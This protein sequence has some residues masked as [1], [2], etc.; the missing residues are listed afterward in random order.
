MVSPP[1]FLPNELS[2]Y[3]SIPNKKEMVQKLLLIPTDLIEFFEIACDDP[4]WVEANPELIDLILRLTTKA[5]YLSLLPHHFAKAITKIIQQHYILLQKHLF[6]RPSLYFTVILYIEKQPKL[7]NSLLFGSSSTFFNQLFKFN[8]FSRFQDEY[9]IKGVSQPLFMLIEEHISRGKIDSLW[10]HEQTEVLS[11]MRQAKSWDFPELVNECADVLKRYINVDNVIDTMINAHKNTF[12]L[13]KT[14]SQEFFNSQDWGLKFIHGSVGELRVELLNYKEQTLEIFNEFS[15]WITHLTFGGRL[16]EDPSF[17]ILIK[18]CPKLIGVDLT[19]TFQYIDQ[20]DH[21]PVELIELNLS[22]CT[23]LK[24][25]HFNKIGSQLPRLKSLILE[26]NLHLHYQ[27]WGELSRIHQ[28]IQLNLSNCSQI[29][30]EDIKNIC[31]ACPNLNELHLEANRKV[32]DFAI[33]DI[34]HLCPKL[35]I[36]N[37][38]R[39]EEISDQALVEIGMHAFNLYDLSLVRCLNI[40]DPALWKLVNLRYTLR[41]LNIKAC[42]FSL[43]MIEKIRKQFPGLELLN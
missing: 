7:I 41:R 37:L 42:D 8:C 15:P 22:L 4:E 43:M 5:Y 21:L 33:N 6:F 32:T 16:S 14:Y 30:D 20:I 18:K 29:T 39:C 26:G 25:V 28:L 36:L 27:S 17:G 9:T 1:S 38:N 3:L 40:T 11:L 34:V 12:E 24:P 31:R 35:S 23:W 13:W 19:S 10:R 2:H